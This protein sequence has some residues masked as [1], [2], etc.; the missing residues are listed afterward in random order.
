M[1]SA[2]CTRSSVRN[3]PGAGPTG[4]GAPGEPRTNGD[5]KG[6][7][8]RFFIFLDPATLL[9]QQADLPNN[10]YTPPDDALDPQPFRSGDFERLLPTPAP[11][12]P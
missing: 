3:A 8:A 5:A 4:T 10:A 6:R 7:W 1:G 2:R 9:G 12:S 11:P